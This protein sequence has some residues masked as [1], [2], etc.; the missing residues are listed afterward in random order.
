MWL[1]KLFVARFIKHCGLKTSNFKPLKCNQQR[2]RT[3][4]LFV[5]MPVFASILVNGNLGSLSIQH[6]YCV[7]RCLW[8]NSFF[9]D[10]W[11]LYNHT[12]GNCAAIGSCTNSWSPWLASARRG[13]AIWLYKRAMRHRNSDQYSFSND[14]LLFADLRDLKPLAHWHASLRTEPDSHAPSCCSP[15]P[16]RAAFSIWLRYLLVPC[17]YLAS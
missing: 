3:N 15:P 1:R 12:I 5:K 6:S 11:S 10:V 9:F 4:F 7:A 13:G 14:D 8:E 16:L 17:R 2:K